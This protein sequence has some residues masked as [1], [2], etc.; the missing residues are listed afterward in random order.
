[1]EQTGT[2]ANSS[3]FS[4]AVAD[5][6][7]RIGGHFDTL[8]PPRP[9][10]LSLCCL[11]PNPMNPG[12]GL[13]VRS[14]VQHLAGLAEVVMVSPVAIVQYGNAK[15]KRLQSGI[16]PARR[17]DGQL[18]VL[19]PRWFY[20]PLSGS[21]TAVW[22]FLQLLPRLAG[23]RK[24]FPFEIIDTH[25]GHPEGVAGALLSLVFKV[26]FT[27][28]LRGNEPKHSRSL[29]GR[30]CTGWSLRRA[31]RVFTV[32]ERLRQFAIDLGAVPQK[33]KVIP[34][35]VDGTVFSPRDRGTCR[36]RHGLS[37]DR[38]LIVSVG[39]LVQRKGH[40]RIIRAL[41]SMSV[42][43]VTPHLAI[44]G[45][46][47]PEGAYEDHLR[48]L[49]SELGLQSSVRFLGPVAPE[50][51]AE[52]MSAADVLC[53]ASTNE[54]WPNV[55]HE[56]LACGTPVV[57]TDVGAVPY[58]LAGGRYGVI[59]PVNDQAALRDALEQSLQKKWDRP[60]IS[61]WGRSRG[62]DQVAGEVLEEIQAVVAADRNS[63]TAG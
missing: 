39:A 32:S 22:L 55:V 44:A 34:N 45:G 63:R 12:Q 24:E 20:L 30:F 16:C 54:G 23:I 14:R 13:F 25:F 21:L 28:T 46:H 57:A 10:I 41:A 49:V 18:S 3:P 60:A 9:R 58:L 40:H 37:P 50:T 38:P 47:G 56:A 8:K 19:H 1:M 5:V 48:R 29:L 36:T 53:L 31:S 7:D 27:M 15:G 4:A 62:W 26:P 35:G 61:A 42:E 17:R 11:Y 51:V 43:G 2:G 52:V 59:V 33:V 6:P